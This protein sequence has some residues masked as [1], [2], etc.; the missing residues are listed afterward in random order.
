MTN[1]LLSVTTTEK[2][3]RLY[4]LPG[5]EY[6]KKLNTSRAYEGLSEGKL[7]PSI[8]NVVGVA[9]GDFSGWAMHMLWKG[10]EQ[11]MTTAEASRYYIRFRDE[12]SDRGSLVHSIIEDTIEEGFEYPYDLPEQPTE[13]LSELVESYNGLGYVHAFQRFC[14]DFRPDFIE[15]ESTVYGQTNPDSAH[16]FDYA[17]TT[18]FVA[19]IGGKTVVGDWKNTK[20]LH[21]SVA[22]QLAAAK[23]ADM[24]AVDGELVEWKSDEIDTGIVVQL[25]PDGNYNVKE[26]NLEKG[27]ERFTNLRKEWY[28]KAFGDDCLLRDFKVQELSYV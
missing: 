22:V 13:K 23:Y 11:G 10:L 1:P 4:Q 26:V 2:I 20:S 27:W 25:C 5:G 28:F 17:G 3:G 21:G 15:Q 7:F 16:A 9:G 12:A 19:N 14:E 24:K 8:T 18:D 6:T